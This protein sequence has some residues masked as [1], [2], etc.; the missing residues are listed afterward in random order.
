MSKRKAHYC[1]RTGKRSK[2]NPEI[3]CTLPREILVQIIQ[4]CSLSQLSGFMFTCKSYFALVWSSVCTVILQKETQLIH[5]NTILRQLA[6]FAMKRF[7]VWAGPQNPSPIT[8]ASMKLLG[9]FPHLEIAVLGKERISSVTDEGVSHLRNLKALTHF[10]LDSCKASATSLSVL[11]DLSLISVL[12]IRGFAISDNES[13]IN[14]VAHFPLNR[15]G[16]W[17]N[18]GR[19]KDSEFKTLVSLTKLDELILANCTRT[20][21]SSFVHL[22]TLTSLRHIGIFHDDIDNYSFEKLLSL[23]NLRSMHIGGCWSLTNISF[24]KIVKLSQ[25]ECL[26]ITRAPLI[27]SEGLLAVSNLRLNNLHLSNCTSIL[28]ADLQILLRITTLARLDLETS[29]TITD[30]GIKN[31]SVHPFIQEFRLVAMSNI[32]NQGIKELVSLTKLSSLC[33]KNC[34]QITREGVN[35]LSDLHKNSLAI[36]YKSAGPLVMVGGN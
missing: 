30:L 9:S 31:I 12:R 36:Q 22:G 35:I 25:L 5:V 11:Q 27:S 6:K 32:T 16:L 10:E 26:A 33:I 7:I 20:D 8:N 28:D 29:G 19:I 15:L 23:V 1:E 14:S 18:S 13:I 17:C 3:L 34:N 24:Q 21:P 2:L 4:L